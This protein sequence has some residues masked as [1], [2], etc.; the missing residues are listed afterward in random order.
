MK[1]G[2]KKIFLFLTYLWLRFDPILRLAFR[3]NWAPRQDFLNIIFGEADAAAFLKQRGKLVRMR[4]KKTPEII[5]PS[6]VDKQLTNFLKLKV[7]TKT[8]RLK[9][10]QII[11]K[12]IYWAT[13]KEVNRANIESY[14]TRCAIVEALLGTMFINSLQS[15]AEI[16]LNGLKKIVFSRTTYLGSKGEPS[17]V[18][19]D[20]IIT[21]VGKILAYHFGEVI[22]LRDEKLDKLAKIKLIQEIQKPKGKTGSLAFSAEMNNKND[23]YRH[24]F[25]LES[26]QANLLI[27]IINHYRFSAWPD[28]RQKAE[29]L[30][31]KIEFQLGFN[32]D[33]SLK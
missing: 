20:V 3:N 10:K 2:L 27:K 25:P 15:E 14:Q 31:K 18:V 1:K 13:D 17:P 4:S 33:E 21:N 32:L 28:S 16:I 9:R 29:E 7:T 8:G 23:A 12:L 11:N 6:Q 26:T 19:H 24:K 5:V 30:V 22:K